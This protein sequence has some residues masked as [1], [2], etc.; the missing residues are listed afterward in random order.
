MNTTITYTREEIQNAINVVLRV[1]YK[2]EAPVAFKIVERAGY[3]T[4][5]SGGQWVV[6]SLKTYKSVKLGYRNG[7]N[8]ACG[9]V[10][11]ENA[12]KVDIINYLDKPVNREWYNAINLYTWGTPTQ[13]KMNRLRWKKE[14]VANREA[15]LEKLAKQLERARKDYV[16][17]EKELLKFRVQ[18]G[19]KV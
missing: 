11:A 3:E 14:A 5:K 16:Q 4:Y 6:R 10:K 1:T 7:L 13:E 17:A 19:L 15:E 9:H 18:N 12:D 2:Y 8:L